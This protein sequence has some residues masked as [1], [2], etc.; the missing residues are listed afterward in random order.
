MLFSV[1]AFLFERDY[2]Y[3]T[4]TGIVLAVILFN[5]GAK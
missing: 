5:M 2:L 4:I 1:F 3:V